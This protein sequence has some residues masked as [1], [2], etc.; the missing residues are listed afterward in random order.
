MNLEQFKQEAEDILEKI[1]SS[2]YFKNAQELSLEISS[3]PELIA[4]SKKRDDAYVVAATTED[5]DLRH[6]KEIEAKEANDA[7]LSSDLVKK[8]MENYRAVKDILNRI[9]DGILKE[10]RYD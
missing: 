3:N 6:K 4:L 8:Y 7:L 1:K 5:M 9:N 10:L 2:S